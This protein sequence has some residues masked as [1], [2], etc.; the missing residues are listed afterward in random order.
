[1]LRRIE[2]G[3]GQSQLSLEGSCACTNEYVKFDWCKTD[4]IALR[5]LGILSVAH[6]PVVSFYQAVEGRKICRDRHISSTVQSYLI[7]HYDS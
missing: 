7:A 2:K 5:V 1:M 4:N 6:A 3:A